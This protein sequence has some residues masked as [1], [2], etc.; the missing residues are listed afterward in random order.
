MMYEEWIFMKL[1]IEC[2]VRNTV[3]SGQSKAKQSK[4]NEKELANNEFDYSYLF[5]YYPLLESG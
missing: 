4:Q 3:S 1:I 5:L 2:V